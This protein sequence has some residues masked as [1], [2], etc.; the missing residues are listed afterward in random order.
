V[1]AIGAPAAV[2]HRPL[3]LAVAGS[4][5]AGAI[6]LWAAANHGEDGTPYVAFFVGAALAQFALAA[7]ILRRQRPWVVLAGAVGT[8]ALLGMF[9]VD[10][11][12]TWLVLGQHRHGDGVPLALGVAAVVAELGTVVALSTMVGGRRRGWLVN[13]ALVAGTAMWALWF[14]GR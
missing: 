1:T 2:E 7:L 9:V 8:I 11:V 6:H 14:A 4:A 5:S 10:K 13:L 3:A 12:T